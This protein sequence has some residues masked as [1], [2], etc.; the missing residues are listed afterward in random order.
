MPRWSHVTTTKS[1]SRAWPW[2]RIAPSSVPPGPPGRKS[3]TGL[4]MLA[5]RIISAWSWPPI[6]TRMSSAMLPAIGLPALGRESASVPA[7]R[8][9]PTVSASS[10]TPTTP[11]VTRRATSPARAHPCVSCRP[12]IWCRAETGANGCAEYQRQQRQE[13]VQSPAQ[14]E[15]ED[16]ERATAAEPDAVHQRTGS[17]RRGSSSKT[18]AKMTGV[19]KHRPAIAQSTSRPDHH[20]EADRDR[21]PGVSRR[22]RLVRRSMP[23][24]R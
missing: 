1:C 21:R 9:I 12:S 7:G 6:G 17:R 5:P 10:A 23:R 22:P 4:S 14:D 19:S 20:G 8:L 3:S 15:R 16:A 11:A 18:A 24:D 13:R 2:R